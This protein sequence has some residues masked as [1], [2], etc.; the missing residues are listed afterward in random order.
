M[1]FRRR[2][3]SIA[4]VSV[5]ILFGGCSQ[6]FMRDTVASGMVD[7]NN[8]YATP[9]FMGSQDTDLSCAMGEGMSGMIFPMGPNV[10]PIIPMLT[11]SSGLCA[12]E[13]S[14]EEELR[15]I[16]ALR[17][18]DV[19]NAQDARIMQ[20][21]W[22]SLAAQ[23]Q[24]F[25]Y[26]AM[27]R[28]F[29]EPS[30]ECPNFSDEAEERSYLFGLLVGLQA[31]QADF[32]SGSE[33]GVPTDIPAKVMAGIKCVDNEKFWGIPQG[34]KAT[35][36]IMMAGI[37]GNKTALADGYARLNQAAK[38]GEKQGVRMV[39]VMQAQVYI[40]Q[41]KPEKVKQVI[42]DHVASIKR[43]ASNPDYRLLDMMATRNL[44]GISDKLWTKATGKRTPFGKLGT[45]WDDK[46]QSSE[47][48]D[49]DDIL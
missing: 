35:T 11:L 2:F 36:D 17:A 42:R 49:I 20:Q 12:L 25:G 37:D 3:F 38:I 8:D 27:V 26:Q 46:S 5:S 48:L 7:F 1:G 9:W 21:R 24:Y 4:A 29:G 33:A 31:F 19:S 13:K 32:S 15:Y 10:D 44:R 16:R 6:H 40:M 30:G 47:G 18:D 23:R 22:L 34:I 43:T 14:Q 39:N 41:N 45:F 28:S